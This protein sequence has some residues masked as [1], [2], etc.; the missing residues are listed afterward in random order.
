MLSC[1]DVKGWK[2]WAMNNFLV[3][4]C[5]WTLLKYFQ[6]SL[7]WKYF[8]IGFKTSRTLLCLWVRF[9]LFCYEMMVGVDSIQNC[10]LPPTN[11]I[12]YPFKSTYNIQNMWFYSF[13]IFYRLYS[14][15]FIIIVTISLFFGFC[16]ILDNQNLWSRFIIQLEKHNNFE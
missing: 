16:I 6:F 15:I 14:H 5:C 13:T 4:Y 2:K 10:F 7:V 11:N 9:T 3:K 1:M 8:G 12:T